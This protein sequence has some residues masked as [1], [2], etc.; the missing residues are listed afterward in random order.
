MIENKTIGDRLLDLLV[1]LVATFISSLCLYP[2]LHVLFASFSDPMLLSLHRGLMFKTAGFSVKGYQVIM[3]N[4]NIWNGYRNT[5]LYVVLGT[6]VNIVMTTPGAYILCRKGW[7]GR[8]FFMFMFVLTMYFSG[9]M[10]PTFLIVRE[11]RMYNTLW[12]LIL[13]TAIS[14]WNMIVMRTAFSSIPDA[15]WESAYLDGAND[16]Q[17]LVR[18]FLPLSKATM[19]VMLLFYAV[20]HWNSWFPAMLYLQDS[21]KYPLQLLLRD[22]LINNSSGGVVEDAEAQYLKELIKYSTIIV[23]TVPILMIYPFAQK[24]FMKGV[25]LGSVKG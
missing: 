6:A 23:A 7:P 12:A 5:I 17:I 19:A 16:L 14:T 21:K 3:N 25:M 9:G 18:I 22:I 8:R 4:P 1:Y 20:G 24:Y 11:L 15:L 13:P 10:I 2:M